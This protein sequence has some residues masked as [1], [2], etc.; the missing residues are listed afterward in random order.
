MSK[1]LL[2]IVLTVIIVAGVCTELYAGSWVRWAGNFAGTSARTFVP[3]ASIGPPICIDNDGG[4]P[5][6]PI[7]SY[8]YAAR[9]APAYGGA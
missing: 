8:C 9:T 4:A 5:P 3:G 1:K 2:T 7:S 6:P